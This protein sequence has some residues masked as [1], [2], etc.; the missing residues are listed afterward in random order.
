MLFTTPTPPQAAL[1][2]WSRVWRYLVAFAV[3]LGAWSV[4]VA[5]RTSFTAEPDDVVAVLMLLDLVLGL[6][7]LCLLPLRRRYPLAVACLT[8]TATMVSTFSAG[9][10]TIALVSMATWRRRSWVVIVGAL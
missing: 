2:R 8:M 5:E 10:A 4:T 6:V 1:S 7:T 3:G 9:P